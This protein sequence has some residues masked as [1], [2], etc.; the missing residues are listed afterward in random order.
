MSILQAF[1]AVGLPVLM[2]VGAILAWRMSKKESIQDEKPAW[3]DDSMDDW[4]KARDLEALAE[5]EQRASQPGGES[6]GA[7]AEEK[8]EKKRHQR[9]GG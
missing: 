8:A 3:R 7:A 6:S 9:I 1:S 4:R 5:R 2:A